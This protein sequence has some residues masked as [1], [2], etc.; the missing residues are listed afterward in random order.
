MHFWCRTKSD[1]HRIEEAAQIQ[2]QD[3]LLIH[4]TQIIHNLG[5]TTASAEIH[6]IIAVITPNVLTTS[7]V[8]QTNT[9]CQYSEKSRE[10]KSCQ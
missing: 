1:P 9:Y 3:G 4:N 8:Y 7:L 6:S 10:R 2:E 5:T